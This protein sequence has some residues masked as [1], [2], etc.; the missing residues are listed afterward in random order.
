[1]TGATVDCIRR[2]AKNAAAGAVVSGLMLGLP[3]AVCAESLNDALAAAYDYNPLLDAERARLRA[4]DEDVARAISGYRPS[5]NATADVGHQHTNTRPDFGQNGST[6]PRGYTVQLVQPIFRGF[7]TTNAVNAAEAAVRAG[8][9][10]LRAT[11]QQV[12]LDTVTAYGDVVRDAAIIKLRQSNLSFLDTELRATRD[13]FTVGEVTRTDVAQ[14]EASRALGLSDLQSAIAN[15]KSS[16]AAYEQV[17]GQPPRGLSESNPNIRLLPKSLDEAIGIGT[18]ENPLVVRALY[19]EQGARFEVDQIRGE[20]LPEAQLEAT[21]SDRFDPSSQIDETE[22]TSIVG[23][24]NVPIYPAGGEVY[25]RV[26][27]A[28]HTHLSRIQ[29][30]EQSRAAAQAQVAQSWAQLQGFRAQRESDRARIEANTTALNGVR[31]EEKVGQR[32]LLDVLDAQQAL[33]QSQITL[34]Q[35]KRNVLVATYTVVSAIGRLSLAELGAASTVYDP[36]IHYEEVRRKW[37]GIDITHDDGR[38]EHLEVER[39]DRWG[40]RVEHEPVK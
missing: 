8:R 11:E 13:R 22:T 32:V 1:M 28:K 10:Q 7:Q 25:A 12:L 40:A 35:T 2:L 6:S 26:R 16:L 15:H 30:I 24:V 23:R 20:L 37:W 5:V 4:T 18:R 33:L 31:E 17:V 21:Y 38:R 27:K 19:T 29:E 14:A 36:E 3:N 39:G 9:E 34:E